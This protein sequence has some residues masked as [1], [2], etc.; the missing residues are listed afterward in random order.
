MKTP[1]AL[2]SL[3]FV[4]AIV[5]LCSCGPRITDEGP[6]QPAAGE[7]A[8]DDGDLPEAD[9]G[10]AQPTLKDLGEKGRRVTVIV[11]PGDA[12]VE[13]DGVAVRRR[14]GVIEL[15]G[16]EGSPPRRLRV[17]KGLQSLEENVTITEAG[18]SPALVDLNAKPAFEPG[19][20]GPGERHDSAGGDEGL[21]TEKFEL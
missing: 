1:R 10:M 6:Q 13:V 9:E 2:Y 16:K 5:G 3:V 12:A 17:F 7:A 21:L 4:Q 19:T 15:I 8:P 14:D 18:A 20:G 11:K